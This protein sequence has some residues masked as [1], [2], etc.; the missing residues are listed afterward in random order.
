MV[1]IPSL[2][3]TQH[4]FLLPST[5]SIVLPALC[6]LFS[7][8]S[9]WIPIVLYKSHCH[10]LSSRTQHGFLL[11]L[12]DSIVLYCIQFSATAQYGF[13]LFSTDTVSFNISAWI[14]IVLNRYT[15][16]SMDSYCS[17]LLYSP[18]IILYGYLLVA[19][20]CNLFKI[21]R[22]V[23]TFDCTFAPHGTL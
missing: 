10:V 15:F 18:L 11:F 19:F 16:L 9:A 8:I 20:D 23:P 2:R 4:E 21:A 22:G 14:P 13:L 6:T 5:D 12:T 1:N 17:V 7:N 3:K